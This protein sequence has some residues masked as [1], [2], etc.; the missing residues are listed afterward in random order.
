VRR[1]APRSASVTPQPQQLRVRSVL[2]SYAAS[3]GYVGENPIAKT[4]K[5]RVT[6]KPV[7]VLTP[8]QTRHLL[9]SA[10]SDILPYFAI[11]AFAGLRSAELGRLDWSE[12]HLDRNF[13]EVS[14]AKSKTASRRLVTILPNLKAWL[15][16]LARKQ[17]PILPPNPRVKIEAARKRA[18]IKRW[19]QN[20][21]RHSF[22][23]YHLQFYADAPAL[24]LQ[25]G[26]T[27][28]AMLFA[29]YREVVSPEAAAAYWMIRP[30]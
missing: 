21:L 16:R 8:K 29:H 10:T 2:F 26:H 30:H 20:G 25:I 4:T 3:R 14:A 13:I 22:A 15:A 11:A 23:S 5:A 12:I 24:A 27:T 1:L 18:G 6:D 17:G 7:E 19:P 9:N 28:T